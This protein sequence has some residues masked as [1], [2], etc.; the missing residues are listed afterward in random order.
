VYTQLITIAHSF[1]G[2]S[3]EWRPLRVYYGVVR[4]YF[5]DLAFREEGYFA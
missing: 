2:H 4:S 5:L 1:C 3:G